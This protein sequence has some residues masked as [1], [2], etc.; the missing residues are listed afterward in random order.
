[1]YLLDSP[2][3]RAPRTGGALP[4]T[5]STARSRSSQNHVGDWKTEIAGALF[6]IG[7]I[8]A[9]FAILGSFDGKLLSDW[10]FSIN[11]N[12]IAAL[13]ATAF[14]STLAYIV[15]QVIS[16]AK[17]LWFSSSTPRQLIDLDRFD[18]GSRGAYGA[19]KLLPKVFRHDF[20]VLL[21][22][23]VMIISLATGPF[24]QQAVGTV[25]CQRPAEREASI[26]VVRNLTDEGVWDTGF[27]PSGAPPPGVV[28]GPVI[29]PTIVAAAVD[30]LVRPSTNR[31]MTPYCET[32]N[33]SFPSWGDP[34]STNH[35]PI[36]HASM[37]VCSRCMDVTDHL[38]SELGVFFPNGS[39]QSSAGQAIGLSVSP[40]QNTTWFNAVASPDILSISASSLINVTI[41][42]LTNSTSGAKM[43]SIAYT[44]SAC[45]LYPCLRS[46]HGQVDKGT[47]TE[48]PVASV[49]IGQVEVSS[50]KAFYAGTQSPCRVA[51]QN[52]V[53]QNMSSAPDASPLNT[54]IITA[55]GIST[56]LMEMPTTCRYSMA[57]SSSVL[58][59][60]VLQSVFNGTCDALLTASSIQPGAVLD[61]ILNCN[62]AWWLSS[63]FDDYNATAD[64]I[65]Q[66]MQSF[67]LA[68]SNEIRQLASQTENVTG[69]T[70]D[71]N[72][73][74]QI[75]WKWITLPAA[76]VTLGAIELAWIIMRSAGYGNTVPIWKR[77][78][79]PF[80]F[81][82]DRFRGKE[83]IDYQDTSKIIA[84]M[85]IEEM[86]AAAKRTH[87][88]L[89]PAD[90]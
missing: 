5:T 4:G 27:M 86:E 25:P 34:G 43:G 60:E 66:Q 2:E 55:T 68:M 57:L 50:G 52:Y 10:K 53:V 65:D 17:W 30:C 9:I 48:I 13:L 59:S 89:L 3:T 42:A 44:S 72:V 35:P 49:A 8:A 69:T 82:G 32:G 76:L 23:C 81:N 7:L 90:S 37:S 22:A 46:Y 21:C 51:D 1:M 36:T 61:F 88:T 75:R 33:C 20:L 73:C 38:L 62:Q 26:S 87:V 18:A 31:L 77:S 24:V 70:W 78:T 41:T 14:R 64:S 39:T 29:P 6:S 19:A 85:N 80:L 40:V 47:S 84:A 63:L 54:T 74:I 15:A 12:T 67:A 45:A 83:G 79:L 71:T 11:V 16:Q 58:L 56:V 28:Y